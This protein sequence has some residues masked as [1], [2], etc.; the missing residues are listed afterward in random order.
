VS[1]NLL[2]ELN[3]DIFKISNLEFLVAL[4]NRI[5][6]IPKNIHDLTKLRGLY[7]SSNRLKS[8]PHSLSK[9]LNLQEC[10]LDNNKIRTIPDCITHLPLLNILSIA[11]NEIVCL[12]ALPW[13]SGTKLM[14]DNNPH[15]HHVPYLVGCQQ[16]ILNYS[17]QASWAVVAGPIAQNLL[18]GVWNIRLYGCSENTDENIMNDLDEELIIV[19]VDCKKN[20][21]LPSKIVNICTIPSL[22]ELCMRKIYRLSYENL[23]MTISLPDDAFIHIPSITVDNTYGMMNYGVMKQYLPLNIRKSFRCGPSTFCC[24]T[25]CC[26]PIFSECYLQVVETDVQRSWI[27]GGNLELK[28]FLATKYFC[29]WN[30]F[31]KNDLEASCWERTINKRSKSWKIINPE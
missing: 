13:I 4:G 12:P 18:D 8:V 24:Y 19:N 29:S 14:L 17:S 30:C 22:L 16:S 28:T 7:V 15:L 21:Y 20:C 3:S 10:Y 27:G 11:N 6:I 5:S 1:H 31:F 2:T 9:C 26:G 23:S 25:R